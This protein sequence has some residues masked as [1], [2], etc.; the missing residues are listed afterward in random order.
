MSRITLRIDLEGHGS[1]GPGK[2]R[3]LE[4]VGEAGS[5]QKAASAMGMSYAHAWKLIQE[6][7][8][9]FGAAL[10]DASSGGR[11]GGGTKLT[12][13]GR[14]VI[15]LY[16]RAEQ[17]AAKAAESE[18]DL[19]KKSARGHTTRRRAIKPKRA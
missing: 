14:K 9:T 2:I 1:I 4:L 11:K 18:I 13:L 19:L 3:L 5:I 10:V 17:R 16:R 6:T 7:G 15:E 8:A 12:A